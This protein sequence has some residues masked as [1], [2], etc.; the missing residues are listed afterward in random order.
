MEA[1]VK[2]H[3]T[4]GTDID[5][6]VTENGI[7]NYCLT[8]GRE[9]Y[10]SG[11]SI[12]SGSYRSHITIGRYTSI[13][14]RVVVEIGLNHNHHLVSNFPFRDFDSSVDP[15]HKMNYVE[16]G[17]HENKADMYLEKILFV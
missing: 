10:I 12:D 15:S 13:S 14:K 17:Y 2:F 9:T 8:V 4:S 5:L 11:M 6:K 7:D 16:F 1:E 3:N